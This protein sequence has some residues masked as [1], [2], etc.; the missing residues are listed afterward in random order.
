MTRRTTQTWDEQRV[1]SY[2]LTMPGVDACNAVYRVQRTVAQR[3]L[4][5]GKVDFRVL[6]AGRRYVVPVVDVL[7]LLGLE[8]GDEQRVG[9]DAA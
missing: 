3:M 4:R 9:G 8:A 7:R 2:G 6:R 5:E 1:R